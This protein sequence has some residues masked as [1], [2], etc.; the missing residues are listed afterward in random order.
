MNTCILVV[1]D[2]RT[3]RSILQALLEEEAYRVETASDGFVAWETLFQHPTDYE[4]ILPD[5]QMPG[6]SGVQVLALLS[7]GQ[8]VLLPSVIVLSVDRESIQQAVEMGVHHVLE[9]P[10]DLEALLAVVS[11]ALRETRPGS[12]F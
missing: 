9:K 6:I 1:D 4:V 3:V 12:T 2:D 11:Q 5:M 10:F 8:A 7:E